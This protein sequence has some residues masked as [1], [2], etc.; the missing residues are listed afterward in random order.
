MNFIPVRGIIATAVAAGTLALALTAAWTD[1]RTRRIPNWLTF[2]AFALGVALNSLF[3][4]W[5]GLRTALLGGVG[6]GLL[7]LFVLL[8]SLGSGDLKLAGAL[9]AFT[10]PGLLMDLLLLS[11]IVAGA[12]AFI[13]IIYKRK[14]RET[15]RNIG[16]IL[17]SL[18]TFKLPSYRAS[19]D[20]ADSLKIPYGVAAAISV[21]PYAAVQWPPRALLIGTLTGILLIGSFEFLNLKLTTMISGRD[22]GRGKVFR[23]D[24][25]NRQ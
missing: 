21:L 12:M 6:L 13:L 11:V 14:L 17:V 18:V 3:Y 23:P 5:G 2:P 19:L 1:F 20:H 25:E 24:S 4:G 16:Y 10:G 15:L 9:G 8:R 7:L 22:V